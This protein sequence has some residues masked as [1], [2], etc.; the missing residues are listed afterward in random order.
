MK[1][2]TQ[3]RAADFLVYEY[4]NMDRFGKI[5]SLHDSDELRYMLFED[6][7]NPGHTIN[8][9]YDDINFFVFYSVGSR[10]DNVSNMWRY[11]NYKKNP[12]EYD[13]HMK[14]LIK[15][16]KNHFTE[17]HKKE[18]NL[19]EIFGFEKPYSN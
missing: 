7:K 15:I 18:I 14:K 11:Y 19:D 3:T 5:I 9:V 6:E 4:G 10:V 1:F 13:E 17:I 2:G 16:Q 12:E 8:A